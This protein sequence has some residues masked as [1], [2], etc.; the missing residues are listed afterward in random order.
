MFRETGYSCFVKRV[1]PLTV[2]TENLLG[3]FSERLAASQ[4]I[5]V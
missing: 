4:R 5:S 2:M 3:Q 1:R